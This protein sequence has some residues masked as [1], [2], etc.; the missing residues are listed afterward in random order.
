MSRNVDSNSFRVRTAIFL[1]DEIRNIISQ[2]HE[3]KSVRLS[4]QKL[5][6]ILTFSGY[7]S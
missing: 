7:L 4:L 1:G 3:L 6:F 5:K 2:A